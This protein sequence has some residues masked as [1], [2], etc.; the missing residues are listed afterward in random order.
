RSG[1]AERG[2]L[3]AVAGRALA[4]PPLRARVRLTAA[5]AA[6]RAGARRAAAFA[7][8][9][10]APRPCVELF[11]GF[12]AAMTLS[13]PSRRDGDSIRRLVPGLR[14]CQSTGAAARRFTSDVGSHINAGLFSVCGDH[15]RS[16]R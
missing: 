10:L 3:T 7:G 11:L 16:V 5:F 2:A 6:G 14:F 13:S 8:R 12:L 4:P 1:S 9:F 15:E